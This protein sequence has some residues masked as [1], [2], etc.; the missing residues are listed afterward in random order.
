MYEDLIAYLLGKK[1]DITNDDLDEFM[2]ILGRVLEISE[3]YGI[4]EK[5]SIIEGMVDRAEIYDMEERKI[6]SNAIG[7]ILQMEDCDDTVN[8]FEDLSND[9]HKAPLRSRKLNRGVFTRSKACRKEKIQSVD[10]SESTT[11]AKV[12]KKTQDEPLAPKIAE[13]TEPQLNKFSDIFSKGIT[14]TDLASS[15][16]NI[17]A[18]ENV[19]S[20]PIE[21]EPKKTFGEIFSQKNSNESK[22]SNGASN[23]NPTTDGIFQ[24]ELG[25]LSENHNEGPEFKFETEEN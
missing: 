16:E 25:D 24:F 6:V 22:S 9:S 8:L 5:Q 19:I 20:S 10:C 4:L 7:N 23:T 18:S 14:D 13:Q 17:K 2:D 1:M 21:I 11:S 3:E 12:L 15:N